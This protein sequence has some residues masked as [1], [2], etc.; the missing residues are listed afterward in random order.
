MSYLWRKQVV[1]ALVPMGIH[2]WGTEEWKHD[3]PKNYRGRADHYLDLPKLYLAS[4][5]NLDISRIYQPNIVTMRV[6]DILACRGFVLA[7]RN[8]ALLE[9]FKEDWDIVCYD[10]PEEA[11]DKI[12][13][14]LNH[15]S[16]RTTIAERGYKKVV[17]SHTFE[18]RINHILSKTGL[19]YPNE[20]A[21]VIPE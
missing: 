2:I 13:Y 11:V 14:Y 6:F 4:K 17:N 7:D 21:V 8:D 15:D 16:D 12:N 1:L 5:I 3:F 20:G 9:L 19:E 18:N 10:T